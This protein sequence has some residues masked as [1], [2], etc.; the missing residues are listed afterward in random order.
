MFA[1]VPKINSR[2][3]IYGVF[4][5]PVAHSASPAMQGAAFAC[6][7]LNCVYLPFLVK[8]ADLKKA[9]AALAPLGI[10]GVNVTI[11]HKEKIIPFLDELSPEAERIGAVNTVAVRQGKLIGYNTDA[12]GFLN[13]LAEDLGFSP[14]G[15]AVFLL[16]AG[17]AARAVAFALAR[18]GA[19][20]VYI[21]DLV[22]GKAR[23]LTTAVKRRFR[24]RRLEA[25]PV[26]PEAMAEKI[27]GCQLLVNATPAG[28][29][30]ADKAPVPEELLRPD[31]AVYDLV[32]NPALTR[33]VQAARERGARAAGGQG[34]LVHQGAIAFQLWTGKPAPLKVMR[35][36]LERHLRGIR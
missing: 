13:S 22:S 19:G 7:G 25:V 26:E 9:T 21:S 10:A 32:Y 33:L 28:M 11:P 23:R 18:A 5:Y 12:G 30:P 3:R 20:A 36:A 15:S 14:G 8:P 1:S 2:T 24:R 34:M 35:K 27:A 29:R 6:R 16:G 4:G 17:G 31:L